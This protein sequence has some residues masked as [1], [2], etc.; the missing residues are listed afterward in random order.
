MVFPVIFEWVGS[1]GGQVGFDARRQRL[2]ADDDFVDAL[3]K[4]LQGVEIAAGDLAAFVKNEDVVAKFF[5]F[6]EDLRGEH[7]GSA[8]LGFF[9][10]R[11]HH[12]AFEN[13]IHAGGKLIQK[14]H[15]SVDHE[16]F[17]HLDAAT[18]STAQVLD[19]ALGFG[20]KI[21]KFNDTVGA[22][23]GFAAIETVKA[24]IGEHIVAHGEEKL[25]GGFLQDHGNLATNMNRLSGN[26]ESFDA[27]SPGSG[28]TKG[29]KDFEQRGFART[30]GAEQPEDNATR[31]L[32]AEAVDGAQWRD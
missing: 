12:G 16:D 11:I 23:A 2:E 29:G 25:D 5:G 28:T 9:A 24:A 21:E 6:T 8:A 14:K 22:E 10:Q 26:V 4:Q 7:D 13:G 30:V 18:V 17:G 3:G 31:N 19:F 15:R 20:G 27:R 1:D 32:K